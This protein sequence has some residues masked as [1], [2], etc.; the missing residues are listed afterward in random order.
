[1]GTDRGQKKDTRQCGTRPAVWRERNRGRIAI[2]AMTLLELIETAP[3]DRS[4]AIKKAD[5][6][7]AA[8]VLR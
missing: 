7:A 4:G 2:A 8:G 1:M 6:G 3:F 5:D